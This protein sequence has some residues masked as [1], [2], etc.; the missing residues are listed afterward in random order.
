MEFSDRRFVILKNLPGYFHAD[1]HGVLQSSLVVVGYL[2]KVG[3]RVHGFEIDQT[4][5]KQ[6]STATPVR[7][8]WGFT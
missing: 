1:F 4:R 5:V 3:F 7:L 6:I 2:C 8:N